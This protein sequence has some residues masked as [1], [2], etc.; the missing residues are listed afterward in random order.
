MA[1]ESL[2]AVIGTAVIDPEFRTAL[3]NGSRRAAVTS[4]GLTSEEMKVVLSIRAATLEQFAGQ[5]D[6]WIMQKLRRV[7]PPELALPLEKHIYQGKIAAHQEPAPMDNSP[8]PLF[9]S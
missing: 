4:F 9:V 2:Q 7:E 6:Q 3:L 1:F 5:L 8:L